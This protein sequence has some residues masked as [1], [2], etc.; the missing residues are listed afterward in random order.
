V[1]RALVLVVPSAGGIL[2]TLYLYVVARGSE[3]D[4]VATEQFPTS[5]VTATQVRLVLE[6]LDHRKAIMAAYGRS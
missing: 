3:S 1:G 6:S 5:G 2:P 4:R